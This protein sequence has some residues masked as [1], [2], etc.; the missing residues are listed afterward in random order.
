[1]N[2]KSSKPGARE[3]VLW[4][5]A[6]TDHIGH[7]VQSPDSHRWFTVRYNSSVRP[8]NSLF[9]SQGVCRNAQRFTDISIEEKKERKKEREKERRKEGRKEG[10]TEGRKEGRK[11]S[12]QIIT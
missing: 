11:G 8:S 9:W 4:L 5:S 3:M 6:L 1:L 2:I 7:P 10:R 12:F